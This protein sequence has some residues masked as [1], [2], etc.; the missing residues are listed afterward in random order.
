[1]AASCTA[2]SGSDRTGMD[3]HFDVVILG[4]G[5]QFDDA[6]VKFARAYAN[7]AER[8]HAALK[9]AVRNGIVDVQP[10]R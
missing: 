3:E 8:D 1:M 10:E 6:M 5:G 4:S 9:A 2:A 7:Q